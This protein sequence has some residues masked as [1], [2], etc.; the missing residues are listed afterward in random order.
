MSYSV[1]QAS[2]TLAHEGDIK[3]FGLPMLL[4]MVGKIKGVIQFEE[5]Q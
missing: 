5:L 4:H 3:L 1:F 2:R